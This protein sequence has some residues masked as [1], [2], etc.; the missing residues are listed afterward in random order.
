L[1]LL[2][3]DVL[4]ASPVLPRKLIIEMAQTPRHKFI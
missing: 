3:R 4:R 2:A 1:L